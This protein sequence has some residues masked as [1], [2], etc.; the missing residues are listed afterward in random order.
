M[1][2]KRF[3]SIELPLYV[4]QTADEKVIATS[5]FTRNLDEFISFLKKAYNSN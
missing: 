2:M 3:N 5:A 1:Q 4:I